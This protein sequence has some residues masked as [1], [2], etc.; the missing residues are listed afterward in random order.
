MTTR[1]D[2]V[3]LMKDR[4]LLLLFMLGVPLTA[5]L[6]GPLPLLGFMSLTSCSSSELTILLVV[7]MWTAASLI[8]VLRWH[9]GPPE[10]ALR[11]PLSQA[12]HWTSLFYA[13]PLSLLSM[14]LNSGAIYLFLVTS[15]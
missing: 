9:A 5:A 1:E 8:E 3:T 6:I 13:L 4:R 15:T 10:A 14:V 7:N 2:L 12:S 11:N